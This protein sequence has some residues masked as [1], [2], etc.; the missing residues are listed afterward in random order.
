MVCDPRLSGSLGSSKIVG[1]TSYLVHLFL[2]SICNCFWFSF[3][4]FL[5][6]GPGDWVPVPKSDRKPSMWPGELKNCWIC[7]KFG[8][9]V[10]FV[11]LYLFF[12]QCSKILIF[13]AGRLGSS[14]KKWPKTLY[15]A[16]RAWKLLDLHEIW[17]EYENVAVVTFPGKF[18]SR[19]KKDF[20][21]LGY[22][23]SPS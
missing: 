19:Q 18:F 13:P 2:L 17:N 6:F 22:S 11:N 3:P 16:W 5:F 14:P 21:F 1:F 8:T 12:I 10:S 15:V 9:F 4:K 23:L 7:M 20:R